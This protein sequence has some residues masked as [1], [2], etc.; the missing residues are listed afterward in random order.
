VIYVAV[1]NLL[2]PIR[3]KIHLRREMA[4]S[5]R[6]FKVRVCGRMCLYSVSMHLLV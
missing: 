1:D 3:A 2:L 6:D 5:L 4:S